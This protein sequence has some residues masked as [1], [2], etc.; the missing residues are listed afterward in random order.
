MPRMKSDKQY[1]RELPATRLLMWAA[2]KRASFWCWIG[3]RI[4]QAGEWAARRERTSGRRLED[5][6]DRHRFVYY[7]VHR[8]NYIPTF[9]RR[10]RGLKYGE[11]P[12]R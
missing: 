12:K 2:G 7:Q 4:R 6:Q 8:Q 5:R 9:I 3:N 10:E 1:R 11:H